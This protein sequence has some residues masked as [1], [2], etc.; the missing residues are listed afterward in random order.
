MVYFSGYNKLSFSNIHNNSRI[1][2][3]TIG[4][5]VCFKKDTE[6]LQQIFKSYGIFSRR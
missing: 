6:Q 2:C 5:N 1:S 3:F 4:W